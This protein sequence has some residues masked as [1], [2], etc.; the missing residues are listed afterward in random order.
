MRLKKPG[1]F[2]EKIIWTLTVFLFVTF[3]VFES[4]PWG[5]YAF[6]GISGLILLVSAIEYGGTVQ[7]RI[8]AYQ[9]F[10]LAF[11][12]F[13][14][15]SALWAFDSAD[16][17]VMAR[18]LFRILLCSTALYWHYARKSDILQLLSAVMWSGFLVAVY[19][20]AF[21]G[22]HTVL[23]AT[24]S[25]STRLSNAY[26]NVNSIGMAC[27]LSC[28]ILFWGLMYRKFRW[29]AVVPAFP[30]LLVMAA[31]QSR[32]AVLFA[33]GGILAL[34]VFRFSAQKSLLNGCLKI[35]LSV[36][37]ITVMFYV[38][39][40]LGL[41]AGVNERLE[42]L[43]NLLT[44]E[45]KVDSST[46]RRRSLIALGMEWWRKYP[47]AG[48]GIGNPHILAERYLNF[49]AYLHNN[50]V[51]LLCGGGII[52]FVLYYSRY[53]YLFVNLWKY[54][55]VEREYFSICSVWLLL[56]LAMDFAVVSYYSKLKNYYFVILFINIE[57]AKRK[58][59]ELG[60]ERKEAR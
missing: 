59:Q 44:D 33:A 54:R 52:G 31:T 29:W 57:C 35:I 48:I 16:A 41:F 40:Q 42:S 28:V 37:A 18:T 6:L 32:K 23:L 15:C 26:A 39:S 4:Y 12:I 7:I 49:D 17:V 43:V 53:A 60:N 8:A 10:S 5:R 34:V 13:A 21:Y 27:A 46:L 51:E 20:I 56:T 14:L 38:L 25:A 22:P 47:I 11:S 30:A 36:A 24:G 50:F 3:L 55:R 2:S 58:K 1:N 19:T 9:G 45:G